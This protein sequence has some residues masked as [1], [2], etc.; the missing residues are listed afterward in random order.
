MRKNNFLFIFFI[1]SVFSIVPCF[2]NVV[3][4]D[5]MSYDVS[6]SMGMPTGFIIPN[7]LTNSAYASAT[8]Q[9]DSNPSSNNDK[10]ISATNTPVITANA[11]ISDT[12]MHSESS[13]FSDANGI[14]AT[15][16]GGVS[17]ADG[18][19]LGYGQV[20]RW[21]DYYPTS[22]GNL[23]VSVPYS[24]SWTTMGTDGWAYAQYSIWLL[25]YDYTDN[26][27]K[28]IQLT[29]Y[30]NTGTGTLTGNLTLQDFSVTAG[31]HIKITE[32]LANAGGDTK[33]PADYTPPIG[34]PEPAA[35]LLLGSGLIG[36]VAFRRRSKK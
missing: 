18:R 21:W 27:N 26:S 22:N 2:S 6:I 33:L 5:V 1:L 31:H 35:M 15:A 7:S 17:V 34:V 11:S 28:N 9:L 25:F 24:I 20:S 10:G 3:H 30:N 14:Y 32:W 19:A 16:T 29:N 8:V 12:G 4:A 23:S 13:G 36:F